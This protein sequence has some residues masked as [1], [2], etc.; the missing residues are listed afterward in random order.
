MRFELLSLENIHWVRLQEHL[1]HYLGYRLVYGNP[2][3][4]SILYNSNVFSNKS[5][6]MLNYLIRDRV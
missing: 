5:N 3:M 1:C 2:D 6:G 4:G